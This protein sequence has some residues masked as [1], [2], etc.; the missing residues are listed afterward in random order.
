MG[1]INFTEKDIRPSDLLEKQK[2]FILKD[3]GY[4]LSYYVDFTLV[5]CPSCDKNNFI[6]KYNKMGFRYVECNICQTIYTNPRPTT[7]ILQDFYENSENYEYWNSH[8]FPASEE[9]R[10]KRI[11]IP[12]VD[13]II[14]LCNKYNIKTDSII[15]VGSGFGTFCEE[16]IN[17]K[18]FNNVIGIEPTKH[19][20]ETCRK[21]GIKIIENINLEDKDK[22][23]V[24]VSFEVIEHLYSPKLFI[25]KCK[26]MLK[27]NGLIV[28]TCPNGQ[29]FD[30]LTLGEKS[31]T[32]DHEH[33]NYFNPKSLKLLF[34]ECD[35]NVLEISTP[36]VLDTD[37]VRNAILDKK[38]DIS[39]QPFLKKILLDEYDLNK[40]SF[41]KY[42][43]ENN[44][45]S[46]MWI[47]AQNK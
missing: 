6:T 31:D 8:I 15:E 14:S 18:I 21:K 1:N 27:S 45:S 26:T 16:V 46:N 39:K 28:V 35:F 41:Q 13:K 38:Y 9:V 22:F 37:I 19:L 3:I 30:V 11:F 4:L 20:A 24:L 23:D 5:N 7:K 43:I 36:G 40:E 17:R 10:K 34:E 32:I 29:G 12:R 2:T 25:E 33:L 42:L 44:L 47:V